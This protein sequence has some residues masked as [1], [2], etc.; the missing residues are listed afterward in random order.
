MPG[1]EAQKEAYEARS[2][3]SSDG[4]GGRLVSLLVFGDSYVCDPLVSRTWP[5]LLGEHFGW[6]ARRRFDQHVSNGK[7]D[8]R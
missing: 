7:F 6:R 2:A 8:G 3:A 5:I 4:Q 1:W